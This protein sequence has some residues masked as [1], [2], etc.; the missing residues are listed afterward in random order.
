MLVTARRSISNPDSKVA[1][2]DAETLDLNPGARVA[3]ELC[4][5]E[6]PGA[7]QA[8]IEEREEQ[9]FS[10][11]RPGAATIRVA[12]QAQDAPTRREQYRVYIY[13]TGAMTI[14][15]QAETTGV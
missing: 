2:S 5:I 14:K 4:G 10:I 11:L 15:P 3:F 12:V 8:A 13:T 9:N 7:G 1:N 6:V